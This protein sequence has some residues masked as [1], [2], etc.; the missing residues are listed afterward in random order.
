MHPEID[1]ATTAIGAAIAAAPIEERLLL[2]EVFLASLQSVV[3][4][5]P[6]VGLS[7]HAALTNDVINHVLRACVVAGHEQ[8][9]IGAEGE[10]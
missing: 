7:G 10:L 9:R 2:G 3:V 1:E 5:A 8:E 4:M 6:L